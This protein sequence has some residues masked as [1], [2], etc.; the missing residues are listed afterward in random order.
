MEKG[1]QRYRIQLFSVRL[2]EA[3]SIVG[4]PLYWLPI[5]CIY[6]FDSNICLPLI[7]CVPSQCSFI[8]EYHRWGAIHKHLDSFKIQI[9]YRIAWN[10]RGRDKTGKR[11]LKKGKKKPMNN[12]QRIFLYSDYS[13]STQPLR[14]F[15]LQHNITLYNVFHPVSSVHLNNGISSHFNIDACAACRTK[16][17]TPKLY[18]NWLEIS[19][20]C[21][22]SRIG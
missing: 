10:D 8:L 3:I 18:L 13:H 15:R 6:S 21:R 11:N 22:R 4:Y 19:Q 5:L 12:L 9:R 20:I 2:I 17:M 14:C 16:L 7:L 1:W